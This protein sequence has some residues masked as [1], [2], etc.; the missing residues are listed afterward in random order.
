[1]VN[2]RIPQPS[3]MFLLL[4]AIVICITVIGIVCQLTQTNGTI[5]TGI[6]GS[7]SGILGWRISAWQKNR[8]P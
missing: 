6:V 4:L 3:F 2:H 5:I 1:M 7:L 8:S